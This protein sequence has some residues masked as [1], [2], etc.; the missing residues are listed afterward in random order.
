[1]Q[2]Q[3][4]SIKT[5]VCA[6]PGQRQLRQLDLF[7][8]SKSKALKCHSKFLKG[9]SGRNHKGQITIRHHGGRHKRLY[10]MVDFARNEGDGIVLSI[11]YDPFRKAPLARVFNFKKGSFFYILAP[12]NL[13]PSSLVR[14]FKDDMSKEI[15]K[16][17]RTVSSDKI[18]PVGQ[19]WDNCRDVETFR[20]SL[21]D[22]VKLSE[23]S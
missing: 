21:G 3:N 1:M 2:L 17:E 20:L 9:K 14:S 12:K 23:F 4:K 16:N 11:D 6:T 13:Y 10:R 19:L 7:F 22:S 15:S 8:L 5:P 18:D